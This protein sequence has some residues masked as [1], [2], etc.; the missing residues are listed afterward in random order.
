[1]V[2][3]KIQNVEITI[4]EMY[5]MEDGLLIITDSYVSKNNFLEFL[6]VYRKFNKPG[7]YFETQ[8]SEKIFN[9]RFGQLLYSKNSNQNG[10]DVRLNFVDCKFDE[11]NENET[12]NF[13]DKVIMNNLRYRNLSKTIL[14]QEIIINKLLDLLLEKELITGAEKEKITNIEEEEINYLSLRKSAEIEAIPLNEYL[15]KERETIS[16]IKNS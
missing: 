11:Q 16:H 14:R 4:N 1:M 6:E 9:G 2:V 10:Y 12:P 5:E 15:E 13:T 3:V 7:S 8:I